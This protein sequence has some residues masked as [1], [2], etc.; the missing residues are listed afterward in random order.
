[1]F[2][3]ACVV[4][5]AQAR[6]LLRTGQRTQDEARGRGIHG[7][8][9]RTSVP[10]LPPERRHV[11]EV[12]SAQVGDVT[13]SSLLIIE[14]KQASGSG[15]KEFVCLFVCF[16]NVRTSYLIPIPAPPHRS[17]PPEEQQ[18]AAGAR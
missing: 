4:A 1:M 10:L 18:Q 6:G 11:S 2:L 13:A 3:S 16:F 14:V 12:L 7:N 9:R 15:R 8:Q 5:L 17:E